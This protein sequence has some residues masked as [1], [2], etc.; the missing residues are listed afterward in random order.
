M[1]VR[2][3]EVALDFPK[4]TIPNWGKILP[5]CRKV[6]DVAHFFHVSVDFLLGETVDRTP[7]TCEFS[8]K[9][10]QLASCTEKLNPPQK[11]IDGMIAMIKVIS[12]SK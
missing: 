12:D 11:V 3:L 5:S 6:I 7:P 8:P 4:N 9:V 2:D 1:T 10:Y